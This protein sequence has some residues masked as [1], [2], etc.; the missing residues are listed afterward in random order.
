[1]SFSNIEVLFGQ[2][3]TDVILKYKLHI[4]F[5][6]EGGKELLYDEIDMITSAD[7]EARN[8]IGFIKMLNN[9]INGH[10][11]R[12]KLPMRNSMDIK[13]SEYR[14][15]M[16][17]FGFTMNFMKKW[18]NEVVLRRGLRFPFKMEELE[19]ELKFMDK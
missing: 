15:F 8:D 11:N 4:A 16:S 1:M 6:I 17:T 2:F 13:P 3:D 10:S 14:E 9:K 19:T 7:I 12:K 18:M 5:S